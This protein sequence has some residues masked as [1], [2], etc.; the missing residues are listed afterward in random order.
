MINRYH[1][2]LHS[3]MGLQEGILTVQEEHGEVRG[4]LRFLSHEL[5]ING[6]RTPDGRLVLAHSVVTPVSTYPCLSI[7]E[8]RG[9]AL[10]GE[11]QMDLS[12]APWS[13]GG[14]QPEVIMPWSGERVEETEKGENQ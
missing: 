8:D 14:Q 7:L 10:S 9:G 1:L 6:S 5:P 4:T 12:E 2:V 11:V 3:Q 13:S